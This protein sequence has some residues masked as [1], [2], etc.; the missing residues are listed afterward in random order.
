MPTGSCG[1]LPPSTAS[2][3]VCVPKVVLSGEGGEDGNMGNEEEGQE[4]T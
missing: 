4:A 3:A 2:D 1:C